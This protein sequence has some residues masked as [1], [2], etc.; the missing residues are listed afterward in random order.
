[1]CECGGVMGETEMGKGKL[2]G[3]S[4]AANRGIWVNSYKPVNVS[5]FLER[6]M[7]IAKHY[8]VKQ[9]YI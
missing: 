2:G 9:C 3:M 1:M 8:G 7:I 6:S 4:R 5:N